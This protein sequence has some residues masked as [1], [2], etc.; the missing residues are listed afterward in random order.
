[1][2]QLFQFVA[3][4]RAKGLAPALLICLAS[5]LLS[6]NLAAPELVVRRAGEEL[7]VSA[8]RFHFLTGKALDRLH[9]GV[10]MPFD[11]QL[12]LFSAS[13]PSPLG[14]TVDRFV[15][16]YDL[17]EE[18]FSVVRL[19]EPR[20]SVSHLTAAAAEAWCLESLRMPINGLDP[21][22]NFRL[23]LE[24]RSEEPK[25]A[26]PLLGEPGISLSALIEVFSRPAR[27]LQQKWTIESS[28]FRLLD[29]RKT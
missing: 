20:L 14:R 8:P 18:K 3:G 29:F 19:R 6:V 23:S 17:W 2:N 26:N 5:P 15:F 11:A 25:E 13:H 21:N 4:R 22:G 16:S 9:D 28:P 27:N 12:S 10:A 24:L 1:L 7:S